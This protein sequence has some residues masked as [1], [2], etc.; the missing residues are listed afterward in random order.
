MCAGTTTVVNAY[1]ADV[2]PPERRAQAF[3]L[4]GS[5]FGLGFVAGPVIGGALGAVDPRL[6]FYAAAGLALANVAYGWWILPESRRG[7]RTTALNLRAVSPVGSITAVLRRPVLGRLMVARF[8]ADIARMTHQVIWTFFVTYQ[9]AWNTA[10]IGMT[11]SAGALAGAVFQARAVGP[12]VRWLGDKRAAVFGSMVGA[13]AL[14]ATA[15]ATSEGTIY[16]LQA[17][18]VLGAVGAAAMQAWISRATGPD[19]QGVV[20]GRAD[21]HGRDRRNGRAGPGRRHLRLVV[22]PRTAR[23]GVPS[24]RD[25]SPPRRT[26]LLATTRAVAS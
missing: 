2:T 14:G 7:D 17:I 5:A 26:L 11:M 10:Q 24:A 20:N 6:P 21:R 12:A 8:C 25:S 22:E 19:E 15:F 13:L 18:G 3:G 16:L 9:L 23:R 1:I 4:V